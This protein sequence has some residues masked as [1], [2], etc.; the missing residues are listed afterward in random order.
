MGRPSLLDQGMCSAG[1]VIATEASV[2]RRPSD[3]AMRCRECARLA[4][5]RHAVGLPSKRANQLTQGRC[6][7]AGHPLEPG[8]YRVFEYDRGSWTQVVV[9]C[10]RCN[11]PRHATAAA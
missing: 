5:I 11:P 4:E 7:K 6:A 3:G 2:I 8:T 1:H 10:L 9:R